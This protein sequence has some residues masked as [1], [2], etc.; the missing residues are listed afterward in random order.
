M[1]GAMPT[2]S[3]HLHHAPRRRSH[4]V[5]TID[6]AAMNAL[7]VSVVIVEERWA[8]EG[9]GAEGIKQGATGYPELSV[10]IVRG[11]TKESR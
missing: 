10:I 8:S 5:A 1:S 11:E 6:A 2:L 9:I 4:L 3:G 7:E